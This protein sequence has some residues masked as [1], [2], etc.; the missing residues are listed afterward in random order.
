MKTK[1]KEKTK[2][3]EDR[4]PALIASSRKMDNVSDQVYILGDYR[5]TWEYIGEGYDGDYDPKDKKDYP[6]LRF[7]CDSRDKEA[8]DESVEW[9]GMDDSSYCTQLPISTPTWML[10]MASDEILKGLGS[11]ICSNKRFLEGKSWLCIYDFNDFDPPKPPKAK[12]PKDLKVKC[13]LIDMGDTENLSHPSLPC[14]IEVLNGTIWISPKGYGDGTPIG[15][16][17]YNGRLRVL[18]WDDINNNG[19]DPVIVD[20]EGAR[21][22]KRKS[23]KME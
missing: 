3:R 2:T 7:S 13:T 4:E 15:V 9:Q 20:M 11:G 1:V 23:G 22:S 16:E 19:G 17:L 5:I 14:T 18:A 8:Y 21:E 12:V 6:H 10:K